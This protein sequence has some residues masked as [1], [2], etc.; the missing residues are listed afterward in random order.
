MQHRDQQQESHLSE[1]TRLLSMYHALSLPQFGRLYPELTDRKLRLLLGRLE[2]AGRLAFVPDRELILYSKE[3]VPNPSTLA[4]F[5]VLLDFRED[6]TYHTASDFPVALTFYTQSDA[7]DVIH[8]PEE[9]EMHMNHALSAYKE[10]SPR[11]IAIVDH[12]RQIPLLHIPGTAAFC[13]V[14]PDG[15]V[16]YYRKQGVTDT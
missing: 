2:K 14:T 10:D 3:C 9:K 4:A 13:T 15:K 16:Q 6:V 1:I 8:I 5:W 12:S 11:R 7:Y